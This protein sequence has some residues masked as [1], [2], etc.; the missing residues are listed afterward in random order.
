MPL[1]RATGLFCSLCTFQA[2]SGVLTDNGYP[3]GT[4]VNV[5]G[6]VEIACQNAPSG[7]VGGNIQATQ[8]KD[9]TEDT[10]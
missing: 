7:G 10:F 2:P 6:L 1:A 5:A 8:K 9:P 3:D 4:F